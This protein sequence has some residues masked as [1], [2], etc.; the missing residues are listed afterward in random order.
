VARKT[1][2]DESSKDE[3]TVEERGDIEDESSKDESTVEETERLQQGRPQ[4]GRK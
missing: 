1:I 2:K 4:Q 3:S